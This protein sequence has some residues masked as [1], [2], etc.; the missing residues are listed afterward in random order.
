MTRKKSV[1]ELNHSSVSIPAGSY[2]FKDVLA[3]QE[4]AA[5]ASDAKRPSLL[6][7]GFEKIRNSVDAGGDDVAEVAAEEKVAA[8]E[9]S[10]TAAPATVKE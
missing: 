2:D 3:L 10:E 1:S 7:E 5:K 6:G 8:E 4:K 9:N